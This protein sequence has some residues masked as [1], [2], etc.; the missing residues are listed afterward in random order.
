MVYLGRGALTRVLKYSPGVMTAMPYSDDPFARAS[1][2]ISKPIASVRAE[3]LHTS[4]CNFSYSRFYQLVAKKVWGA[5]LSQAGYLCSLSSH[6]AKVRIPLP[7]ISKEMKTNICRVN[8]SSTKTFIIPAH[9]QLFCET[10]MLLVLISNRV[11]FWKSYQQR[12][13]IAGF[14][15]L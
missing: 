7:S 8:K 5:K 10:I 12:S 2:S 1:N 3:W 6:R 15:I 13:V 4:M 11:W 14:H 9:I